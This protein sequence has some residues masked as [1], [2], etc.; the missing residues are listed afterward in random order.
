MHENPKANY[1]WLIKGLE[2]TFPEPDLKAR[3]ML[4]H[5]I[6]FFTFLSLNSLSVRGFFR[7]SITC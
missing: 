6:D 1:G 3:L 5:W 2:A 4:Y 7:P